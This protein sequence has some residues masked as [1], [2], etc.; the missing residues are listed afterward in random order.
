MAG[1]HHARRFGQL[2]KTWDW[3]AQFLSVAAPEPLARAT[4]PAPP[5]HVHGVASIP[6]SKP[7]PIA[8]DTEF[9]RE[10]STTAGATPASSSLAAFSTVNQPV[11]VKPSP[12]KPAVD[13]TRGSADNAIA[14]S[15]SSS[16]V[17]SPLPAPSEP[18]TV[19]PSKSAP[20][21]SPEFNALR[22]TQGPPSSRVRIPKSAQCPGGSPLNGAPPE[23]VEKAPRA[24][25]RE[26][27]RYNGGW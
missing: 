13:V 18:F 23:D 4:S 19:N 1:R 5:P 20:P 22:Q 15:G 27:Q 17:A 7:A 8:P 24:Q 2:S 14:K 6:T 11:P 3:A 12:H 26:S 21:P 16:A 10:D 25:P 9:S